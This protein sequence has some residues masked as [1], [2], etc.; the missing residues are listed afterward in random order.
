MPP[1]AANTPV[2]IAAC[3]VDL[4]HYALSYE[5]EISCFHHL[6]DKLMPW[7]PTKTVV[8][9]AKFEIGVADPAI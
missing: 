3:E 8:A 2:A 5:R 7:S 6:A 4:A 9:T 1:E